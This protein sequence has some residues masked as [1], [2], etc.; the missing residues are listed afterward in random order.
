MILTGGGGGISTKF[1]YYRLQYHPLHLPAAVSS[2]TNIIANYD[3]HTQ[4]EMDSL[5]MVFG[6]PIMPFARRPVVVG[7]HYGG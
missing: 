6:A 5:Q 1:K 2:S 4:E 3:F 7:F